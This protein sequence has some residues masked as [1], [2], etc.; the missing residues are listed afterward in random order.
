MISCALEKPATMNRNSYLYEY[1]DSYEEE[2]RKE[3]A[4]IEC[5]Y[6][7]RIRCWL[8]ARRK[9]SRRLANKGLIY[10]GFLSISKEE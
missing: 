9:L 2:R 4:I 8:Y 7:E 5:S 10:T 3:I 6:E 1:L